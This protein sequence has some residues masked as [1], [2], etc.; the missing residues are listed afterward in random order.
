MKRENSI[1]LLLLCFTTNTFAQQYPGYS[2]YVFDG[3]LINPAY[4]GTCEV[5]TAT[6]LYR[7]QYINLPTIQPPTN[8]LSNFTSGSHEI[9]LRYQ[10]DFSKCK[11]LSPRFF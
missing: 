5:L 11:I 10:F 7:N 6:A 2:Q 8:E 3:L 1:F 9:M 4:A